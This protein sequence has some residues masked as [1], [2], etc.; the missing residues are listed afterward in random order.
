M[1]TSKLGRFS[2]LLSAAVSVL[3][4][5]FAVASSLSAAPPVNPPCVPL[6]GTFY[7]TF[8]EFGD[9]GATAHGEGTVMDGDVQIATF[10][11]EYN[12]DQQGK[13][14]I[15]STASHT[16]TFVDEDGF[17]TGDYLIT[18]D[19]IRLL[20]G[21]AN[22]QLYIVGGGGIYTDATGLLHTHGT[23]AEGISFKGQVCI[24][25]AEE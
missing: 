13:G 9:G 17:A 12:L 21:R 25:T 7:F 11:A 1:I 5:G 2:A 14:V 3:M 24:P 16:I 22:S 15:H 20:D 6:S 10:V 18:S 8:L 4:V 19:R 23:I